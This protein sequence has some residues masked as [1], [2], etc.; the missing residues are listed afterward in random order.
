MRM[1]SHDTS[2][3]VNFLFVCLMSLFV[4]INGK[5]SINYI[6]VN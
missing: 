1:L 5:H 2:A 3:L 4:D 6:L